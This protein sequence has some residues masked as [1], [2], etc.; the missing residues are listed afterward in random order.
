M[1]G[2]HD[3]IYR[4]IPFCCG[5]IC[6]CRFFDGARSC[7]TAAGTTDT[8]FSATGNNTENT[9]A[10]A[11]GADYKTDHNT[12]HNTENTAAAATGADYKTD[13]NTEN[14]AAAAT[15]ADHKTGAAGKTG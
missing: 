4:I 9:A 1:K 7:A 14:T 12:D 2:G 15:G 11:T 6:R 13:H 10:A 3:E 8:S 5:V